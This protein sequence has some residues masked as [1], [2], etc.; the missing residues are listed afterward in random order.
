MITYE[1]IKNS[2]GDLYEKGK[3]VTI[4]GRLIDNGSSHVFRLLLSVNE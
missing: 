4:A 1:E 2:E 3:E